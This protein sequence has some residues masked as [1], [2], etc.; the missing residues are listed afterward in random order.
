MSKLETESV[1]KGLARTSFIGE[2]LE[3]ILRHPLTVAL[4]FC[5]TVAL[6][7]AY[8]LRGVFERNGYFLIENYHYAM[9]GIFIPLTVFLIGAIWNFWFVPYSVVFNYMYFEDVLYFLIQGR[10]PPQRLPWLKGNPHPTMILAQ[11]F[12]GCFFILLME[13]QVK[14]WVKRYYIEEKQS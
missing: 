10:W 6:M 2:K 13:F 3:R 7:D 4:Y 1:Q 8:M 11:V 5:L 9:W 14:K 12:L